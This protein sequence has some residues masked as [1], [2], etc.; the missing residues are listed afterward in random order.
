MIFQ[1]NGQIGSQDRTL[2]DV[3]MDNRSATKVNI[4]IG[5]RSILDVE[6]DF[7]YQIESIISLCEDYG[8]CFDT[9]SGFLDLRTVN[10][11]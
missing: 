11:T 9:F 5:L 2:R 10:A 8:T 1:K 7:I 4:S 6:D 3:I